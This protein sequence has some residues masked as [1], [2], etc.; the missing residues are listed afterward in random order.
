MSIDV[1]LSI[2]RDYFKRM[3]Q[4]FVIE[5]RY[6]FLPED[7]ALQK[8]VEIPKKIEKTEINEKI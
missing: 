6:Y 4:P 1:G 2:A 5:R 7:L 8:K 3:A